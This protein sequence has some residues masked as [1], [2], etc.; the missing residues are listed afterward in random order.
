ME[1]I[2]I[3][4]KS[5]PPLYIAIEPPPR[6][7]SH[8]SSVSQSGVIRD[9][10]L[11]ESRLFRFM[12]V[13]EDFLEVDYHFFCL[14]FLFRFLNVGSLKYGIKALKSFFIFSDFLQKLDFFFL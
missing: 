6:T 3:H 13:S 4:F 5:Y 14:Y 11:G 2:W 12:T 1:A 9:T 8:Y 7:L 10:C